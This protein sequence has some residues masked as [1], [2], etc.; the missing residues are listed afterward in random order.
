MKV[1]CLIAKNIYNVI[2]LGLKIKNIKDTNYK[3]RLYHIG[4]ESVWFDNRGYKRNDS[5]GIDDKGYDSI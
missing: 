5:I 2:V 1:S 4:I 3:T